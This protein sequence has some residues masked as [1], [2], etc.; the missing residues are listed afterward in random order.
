MTVNYVLFHTLGC[1]L[2]ELAEKVISEVNETDGRLCIIEFS[3]VDIADDVDL[4]EKYG[5]KIPVLLCTD[6][7][8]ELCWP[9][10]AEQVV[11]RFVS[12]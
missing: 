11:A 7:G 1:H 12:N 2:C 9:F 6:S 8:Q 4:I 5:V 3:K 10:D